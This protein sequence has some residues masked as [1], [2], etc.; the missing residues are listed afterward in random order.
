MDEGMRR[1]ATCIKMVLNSVLNCT[2]YIKSVV[3]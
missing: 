1:C 3:R 2:S